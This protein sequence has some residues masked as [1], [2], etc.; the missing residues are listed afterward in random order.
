MN[1]GGRFQP[2]RATGER[3]WCLQSGVA[4]GAVCLGIS[5]CDSSRARTGL[6]HLGSARHV[7]CIVAR[8]GPCAGSG[9]GPNKAGLL[10]RRSACCRAMYVCVWG[11]GAGGLRVA[12]F[13]CVIRAARVVE[14]CAALQGLPSAS[15][16]CGN[17]GTC[18]AASQP[19]HRSRCVL[20]LGML[21]SFASNAAQT[22]ML[23]SFESVAS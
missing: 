9:E 6:L 21:L 23:Y 22:A 11:K 7:G 4:L 2:E 18:A 17:R 19:F 3:I 5:F 8:Q 1:H 20:F 13:A 15:V 16:P 12:D 14:G 10:I